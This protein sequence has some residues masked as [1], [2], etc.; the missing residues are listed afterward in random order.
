[1]DKGRLALVYKGD[2]LFSKIV[3]KYRDRT[4]AMNQQSRAERLTLTVTLGPLSAAKVQTQ[5][6]ISFGLLCAS[7]DRDSFVSRA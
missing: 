7:L 1:L 3:G 5:S 4:P 2:N 6:A